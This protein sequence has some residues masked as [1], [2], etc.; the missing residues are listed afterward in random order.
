MNPQDILNVLQSL[1]SN[2]MQ[3]LLQKRL[4][5]P[6]EISNDPNKILQYLLSTGQVSQEQYNAAYQQAMMFKKR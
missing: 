5:I 3:F 2:P 1:K 6:Q 4:N